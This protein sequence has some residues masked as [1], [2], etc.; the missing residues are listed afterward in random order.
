MPIKKPT[1]KII[2]TWVSLLTETRPQI[3]RLTFDKYSV[4]T[5]SECHHKPRPESSSDGVPTANE[6]EAAQGNLEENRRKGNEDRGWTRG[7]LDRL[8][9]DRNQ[10]SPLAEGRGRTGRTK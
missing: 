5:L 8:A 1:D 2:K 6:R 9:T 3:A 10:W 7:K 4:S